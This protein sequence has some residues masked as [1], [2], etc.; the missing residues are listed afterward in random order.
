MLYGSSFP[1][2]IFVDSF[3]LQEKAQR[4]TAGLKINEPKQTLENQQNQNFSITPIEIKCA[5]PNC[6]LIDSNHVF[7]AQTWSWL[8]GKMHDVILC[9]RH[10]DV[11]DLKTYKYLSRYGEVVSLRKDPITIDKCNTDASDKG[12]KR[13]SEMSIDSANPRKKIMVDTKT[14]DEI[15]NESVEE[16][17]TEN[18]SSSG[19]SKREKSQY[20]RSIF[21]NVIK[22]PNRQR[23]RA[24]KQKQP[25]STLGVFTSYLSDNGPPELPTPESSTSSIEATSKDLPQNASDVS[26]IIQSSTLPSQTSNVLLEHKELKVMVDQLQSRLKVLEEKRLEK[27]PTSGKEDGRQ[28]QDMMMHSSHIKNEGEKRNCC[29]PGC[30]SDEIESIKVGEGPNLENIFVCSQHR[31]CFKTIPDI[32]LKAPSNDK[33]QQA[34]IPVL[35]IQPT[36][37]SSKDA[38]EFDARGNKL[39]SRKCVL[40]PQGRG[41]RSH[42]MEEWSDGSINFTPAPKGLPLGNCTKEQIAFYNVK[43]IQVGT[44]S[45]PR[46]KP[47]E[48]NQLDQS[49]PKPFASTPQTAVTHDPSTTQSEH[50]VANPA[51]TQGS[52]SST[53]GKF[54]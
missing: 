27:V 54:L 31:D 37:L 53:P 1:I 24:R 10:R 48:T 17:I 12:I 5:F 14:C 25:L 21:K 46:A 51:Q 38:D 3:D 16:M 7:V 33:A 40:R 41:R 13:Y 30:K 39:V 8:D 49:S 2:Q 36:F 23:G 26:S 45:V 22:K 44:S 34:E 29:I 11:T 15:S 35:R 50:P 47:A 32:D 28:C 20:W 4:K 19:G 43:R 52:S 6:G 42:I 18:P 9:E